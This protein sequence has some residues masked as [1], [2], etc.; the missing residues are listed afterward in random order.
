MPTVAHHSGRVMD[1][2]ASINGQ[3]ENTVTP[4]VTTNVT[5]FTGFSVP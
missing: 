3:M 4:T 2:N 1:F 5:L